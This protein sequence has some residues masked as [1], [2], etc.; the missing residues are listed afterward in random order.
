MTIAWKKRKI[1]SRFNFRGV[2]YCPLQ[3]CIVLGP[4]RDKI[5]IE[6]R[7]AAPRAAHKLI[8]NTHFLN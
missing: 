2:A 5:I 7:R 6:K 8:I 4:Q 3:F 1:S